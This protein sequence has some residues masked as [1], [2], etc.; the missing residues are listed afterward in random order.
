MR[1]ITIFRNE[2]NSNAPPPS[3]EEMALHREEMGREIEKAIAAGT[4]VSTGGIGLREKTGGRIHNKGGTITVEAPPRGDG[5]WMAAGGFGI[6]NADSREALIETLSQQILKMGE[7]SVEFI[8]YNQFYP[9]PEARFAPPT[10]PSYPAGVIPYLSFDNATEV[11]AF[12]IKAFGAKEIARMY[13]ADGKRIMHCQLE[14]NGGG[15]MLSDNFVEYGL[16]PI[17]RSRSYVMQ[18]VVPDGDI[19]WDRAVKAGCRETM[20]FAVAPWGDRYG[21]M[22]DPFGVTWSVSCPAKP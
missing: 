19:W 16:P 5:G 2:P 14:I 21:Q 10:S 3:D 4:M 12:Y 13:G 22:L 6:V 7:G 17:Q 8:H 15:L 20:P 1:F 9:A 11:I 18:L